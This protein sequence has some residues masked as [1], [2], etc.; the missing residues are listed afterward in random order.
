MLKFYTQINFN[1]SPFRNTLSMTYPNSVCYTLYGLLSW[2]C[3]TNLRDLYLFLQL[4][5][6]KSLCVCLGVCARVSV[7]VYERNFKFRFVG[8]YPAIT[9]YFR[10]CVF[11]CSSESGICRDEWGMGKIGRKE[12][13]GPTICDLVRLLTNKARAAS[14]AL[15]LALI[16]KHYLWNFLILYFSLAALFFT[17]CAKLF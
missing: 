11:F 16:W 15:S 10:L 12:S 2:K 6:W 17:L 5:C 1:L 4:Y 8:F 9:N 3:T 13:G 7:F 14:S